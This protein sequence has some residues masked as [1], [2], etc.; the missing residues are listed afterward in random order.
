MDQQPQP[1][2]LE[3]LEHLW[4]ECEDTTRPAW[5]KAFNEKDH[6]A[7]KQAHNNH[8]NLLQTILDNANRW[9][10]SG[11]HSPV[12]DLPREQRAHAKAKVQEYIRLVL[13]E[14]RRILKLKGEIP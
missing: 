4:E 13:T 7:E 3:E 9:R 11:G 8:Q 10:S 1:L 5:E 12:L 2:S 6:E 14:R